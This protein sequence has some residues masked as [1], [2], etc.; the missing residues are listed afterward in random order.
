MARPKKEVKDTKKK[1]SKVKSTK[2]VSKNETKNSHVKSVKRMIRPGDGRIV[3]GVSLALANYF[4]IDPVIIRLLFVVATIYG[5]SGLI[6]Y[7][8]LWVALPEEGDE[9]LS[10]QQI[11]NENSKEIEDKVTKM[12]YD[13][14]EIAN[15][16][17]TQV[18]IGV[19]VILLGMYLTLTSFNLI[20]F[21]DFGFILSKLW[22]LIIIGVGVAILMSTNN[23]KEE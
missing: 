9:N 15:Q 18:W 23:G 22:P 21:V 8:I 13:V 3:G 2:S 19:G 16:R 1:V 17:N 14:Q 20:P 4:N 10:S 11:I 5:G 7:I 6:L 12:T